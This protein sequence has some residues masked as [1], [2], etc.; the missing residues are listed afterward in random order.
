MNGPSSSGS[1]QGP[2]D[3]KAVIEEIRNL[4]IGRGNPTSVE[5]QIQEVWAKHVESVKAGRYLIGSVEEENRLGRK[6]DGE[7]AF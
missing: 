6:A 2:G 3:A 4:K 1:G 7:L 5:K